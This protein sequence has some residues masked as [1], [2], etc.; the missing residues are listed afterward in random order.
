MKKMSKTKIEKKISKKCS[1]VKIEKKSNEKTKKPKQSDQIGETILFQKRAKGA[2]SK[3]APVA[4]Q[5][6]TKLRKCK[7]IQIENT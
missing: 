6:K 5:K 7:E 4:K 3:D 2:P 1:K